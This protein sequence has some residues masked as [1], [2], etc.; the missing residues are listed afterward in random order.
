M[1]KGRRREAGNTWQLAEAKNKFSEVFTRTI[2]EGPQRVTR[3][4]EEIVLLSGEAYEELIAATKPK[5]NFIKHLLAI[6]KGTGLD[7]TRE[8]SYPREID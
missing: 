6:P 2:E 4:G 1:L 8:K 3:R 5:K 7:L